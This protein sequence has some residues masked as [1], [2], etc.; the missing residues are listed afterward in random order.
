VDLATLYGELARDLPA[1]EDAEHRSL[2]ASE[3]PK[4]PTRLTTASINMF[5]GQH[6]WYPSATFDLI[7]LSADAQTFRQ[8][9]VLCLGVL[10]HEDVEAVELETTAP[11]SELKIVRIELLRYDVIRGFE[12]SGGLF[13][14]PVA[15]RYGFEGLGSGDPFER[16]S[17]W[18]WKQMRREDKPHVELLEA[19]GQTVG[20]SKVRDRVSGFGNDQALANMATLFLDFGGQQE[21]DCYYLFG[22]DLATYSAEL[23]IG[24]PNTDW[25]CI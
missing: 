17:R 18:M 20:S 21:R 11:G 5:A 2:T 3:I 13:V 4:P 25:W 9:G 22:D 23:A 19:D 6:L 8:L 14:R 7:R 1:D 16:D 12:R 24:L 15:V 10:L